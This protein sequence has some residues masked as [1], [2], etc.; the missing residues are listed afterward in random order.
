[1]AGVYG[2]INSRVDYDHVLR[3]ATEIV[4]RILA[5]TPNNGILQHIG[6]ELDA[7]RR[8]SENSREPSHSERSSI[9]LGLIAAR[10]LSGVTGEVGDLADKLFSLN[11]YFEDWPTD[12]AAANATDDDF[13]DDE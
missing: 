6:K 10:E 8:W 2:E 1:M 5:R 12:D 7:M 11:N 13:F 9:D 4:R 3:E